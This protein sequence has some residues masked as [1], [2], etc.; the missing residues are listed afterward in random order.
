M[1]MAESGS[2][3]LIFSWP[4]HDVGRWRCDVV[5][6]FGG[7]SN[8]SAMAA[9]EV[10]PRAYKNKNGIVVCA[11]CNPTGASDAPSLRPISM[12]WER[13]TGLNLILAMS[14]YSRASMF[15]C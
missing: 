10:V 12:W 1:K 4:A 15:T 3:L 5:R 9:A 7:G 2:D 8:Q 6:H 14:Q 11:C 13:M